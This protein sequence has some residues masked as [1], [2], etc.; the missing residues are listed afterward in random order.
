MISSVRESN[1]WAATRDHLAP[2][3]MLVRVENRV[4]VGFP[5]VLYVLRGVTG[6]L[7]MKADLTSLTLEQ[8]LFG[9]GWTR[10]KGLWHLLL[11]DASG[12]RLWDAAGARAI[13]E[14]GDPEPLVTSG[15][16]FPLK[17]ILQHLSPRA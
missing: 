9:E 10:E 6:L 16:R 1:A 3:G 8:V 7:E 15:S 13:Y 4:L 11:H 2:F 12:W 14:S 5:D 17:F